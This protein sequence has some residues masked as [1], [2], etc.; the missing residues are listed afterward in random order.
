MKEHEFKFTPSV[1]LL[2][3]YLV[4]FLWIVFWIEQQFKISFSNYGIYPRTFSGL[5][6]ILF[7]P[8]LH[9]DLGH[10]FNNSLALL[11]L[12]ASLRFFYRDNSFQVLFYGILLSGIGT[13]LIG[14]E[15]YH[16]GASGLVY[17]LASFIFFKGIQ[18]RYYRLVALSFTVILLYGGM[19]WYIFPNAETHISWESH[20]S[21]FLVGLLFSW[22]YSSPLY[23]K[24]MI[25]DWQKP[26]YDSSKDPFMKHFDGKGNFISSSKMRELELE[27]WNYFVSN[28][29]VI[30]NYKK[31]ED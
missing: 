17:V 7:S 16:I 18:T 8:F 28:L 2:P 26:D 31:K 10:L 30:Y 15:S 22:L 24:P 9:G 1:V 6:G 27:K 11:F 25:Y 20:L 21:G 19:I 12:L 29:P 13:W 4:L 3:L 14:R 23:Q 5:K